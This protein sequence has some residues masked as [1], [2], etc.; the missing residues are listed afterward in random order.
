[1]Y[2]H[3]ECNSGSD[4]EADRQNRQ[5]EIPRSCLDQQSDLH[6]A[7]VLRAGDASMM[8]T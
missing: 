1:M 4:A 8:P 6:A 5:E 2:K 3:L 7:A